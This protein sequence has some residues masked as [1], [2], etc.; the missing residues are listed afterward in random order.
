MSHLHMKVNLFKKLGHLR[1]HFFP[2]LDNHI[3]LGISP[4]KL[5][6]SCK[7]FRVLGPTI[8]PLL[9]EAKRAIT[10]VNCVIENCVLKLKTRSC[11]V[12]SQVSAES[13]NL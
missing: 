4:F 6:E 13:G 3:T 1:I 7:S 9:Q 11:E 5:K 2:N 8:L 12:A 10:S